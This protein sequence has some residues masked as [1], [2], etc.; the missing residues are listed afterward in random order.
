MMGVWDVVILISGVLIVAVWSIAGLI[1]VGLT[2]FY[3]YQKGD[4]ASVV[5]IYI[6]RIL[7]GPAVWAAWILQEVSAYKSKKRNKTNGSK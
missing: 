6:T 4:R 2:E 3:D 5:K 7:G 1:I